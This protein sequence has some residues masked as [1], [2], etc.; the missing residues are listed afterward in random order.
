MG[1]LSRTVTEMRKILL[2]SISSR[3]DSAVSGFL[4]ELN[5]SAEKSGQSAVIVSLAQQ[6]AKVVE[7]TIEKNEMGEERAEQFRRKCCDLV[8]DRIL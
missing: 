2:N 6:L 1:E 5:T 3:L 7:E 8:L 4:G